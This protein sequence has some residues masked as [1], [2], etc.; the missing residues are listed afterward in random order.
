MGINERGIVMKYIR[1]KDGIIEVNPTLT[2]EQIDISLGKNTPRADTIEELCDEFIFIESGIIHTVS[3]LAEAKDRL[4]EY[5]D[6]NNYE[7][8]LIGRIKFVLDAKAVAE[9]KELT[10]GRYKGCYDWALL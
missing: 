10:E 1:T 6:F 2:N 3:C 9:F 8:R 4:L 5:R 7:Q